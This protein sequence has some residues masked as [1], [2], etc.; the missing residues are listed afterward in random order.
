MREINYI[1]IRDI[2]TFLEQQE[3]KNYYKLKRVSNFW[4]NSYIE[5]K[6]NGDRYKNLSLSMNILI[7]LNLTWGI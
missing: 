7:K 2:R 3:E 5:Y 4:N 6:S 1:L